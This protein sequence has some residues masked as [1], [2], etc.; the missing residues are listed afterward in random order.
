MVQL[1]LAP[2]LADGSP[3]P[4]PFSWST[5]DAGLAQPVGLNADG[6]ANPADTTPTGP[7]V[8]VLTPAGPGTA[9][10][11]AQSAS[12]NVDGNSIELTITEARHG[13]VNLSVGTPVSDTPTP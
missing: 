4:G 12:A 3:D 13:S 1:S 10:V 5:T 8:W 9:T 11:T 2:K 7:V 6:S